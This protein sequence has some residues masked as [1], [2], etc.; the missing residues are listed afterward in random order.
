M[1]Y[2]GIDPVMRIWLSGAKTYIDT[3]DIGSVVP[4][5][6]LGLVIDSASKKWKKGF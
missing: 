5:F 2:I 6:G 3:V 4:A 1:I